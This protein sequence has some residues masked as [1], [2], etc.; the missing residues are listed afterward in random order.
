MTARPFH[1]IYLYQIKKSI[2]KEQTEAIK[3]I[4]KKIIHKSIQANTTGT[5]KQ[6]AQ[7]SSPSYST[8]LV[9]QK[10]SLLQMYILKHANNTSA[11]IQPLP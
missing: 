1:L 6:A 10:K 4:P 3:N 2:K 5:W 8:S 7:L 9:Y 11:E